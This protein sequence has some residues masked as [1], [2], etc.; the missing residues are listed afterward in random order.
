VIINIS[1]KNAVKLNLKKLKNIF[2]KT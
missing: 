1:G 2:L